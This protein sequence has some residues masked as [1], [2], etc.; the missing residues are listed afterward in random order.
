[1]AIHSLTIDRFSALYFQID[2]SQRMTSHRSGTLRE[3]LCIVSPVTE[4]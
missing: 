1:M 3:R 2:G 4:D